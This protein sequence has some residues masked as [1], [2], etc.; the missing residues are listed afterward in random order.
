VVYKDKTN[1]LSHNRPT[2]K[3]DTTEKEI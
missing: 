1:L 2:Y 3:L